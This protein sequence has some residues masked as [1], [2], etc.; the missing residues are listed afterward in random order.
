MQ[1]LFNF[2]RILNLFLMNSIGIFRLFAGQR[3]QFIHI[4]HIFDSSDCLSI[5]VTNY[6]VDFQNCFLFFYFKFPYLSFIHFFYLVHT[7]KVIRFNG[8]MGIF[9]RMAKI[10][11]RNTFMIGWPFS[12]LLV[13][14]NCR[15]IWALSFKGKE[16]LIFRLI[17]RFHQINLCSEAHTKE[18]EFL[19]KF[20]YFK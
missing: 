3:I 17:S 10:S 7:L 14:T 8:L 6:I 16:A 11:F 4:N 12:V 19:V 15:D 18:R 1:N 13:N 2:F 20:K 5:L 9:Y